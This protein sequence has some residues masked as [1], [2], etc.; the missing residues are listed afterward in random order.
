MLQSERGVNSILITILC[1]LLSSW[2][3]RTV[4]FTV[5]FSARR[6]DHFQKKWS[7]ADLPFR[8]CK[9]GSEIL[10]LF[11]AE[12]LSFV[13]FV[14]LQLCSILAYFKKNEV[15]IELKNM[16]LRKKLFDVQLG[17]CFTPRV[18]IF[19][20]FIGFSKMQLTKTGRSVLDKL[21]FK[22]STNNAL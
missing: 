17:N 18:L 9:I 16:L 19:C 11:L 14:L 22:W 20:R 3:D 13:C 1:F 8:F 7:K 4:C 10:Y 6:E 21:F 12:K 15:L 5:S 2:K